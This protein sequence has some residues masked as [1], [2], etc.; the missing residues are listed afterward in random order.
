[1]TQVPRPRRVF[2]A[3]VVTALATLAVPAPSASAVPSPAG[4]TDARSVLSSLDHQ[5]LQALH[6]MATLDVGGLRVTDKAALRSAKP[7]DVIVQLS[8]PPAR[9]ARL[10]AAARGGSLSDAD[11]KAAVTKS[12]E[13]FRSALEDMFPS[14]SRTR[15]ST[16]TSTQPGLPTPSVCTA[17]TRTASTASASACQATASPTCSSRTGS[18]RSGRTEMKAFADHEAV[19][20]VAGR[21]PAAQGHLTTGTERRHRLPCSASVP[22]PLSVT[23]LRRTEHLHS[24]PRPMPQHGRTTLD[25]SGFRPPRAQV[26]AH[27]P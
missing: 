25:H 20:A 17:V 3:S 27:L 11:A 9:T 8:T 23:P 12:H 24:V 18:R 4:G 22:R 5:E 10:L 1:M 21:E 14:A 13:K 19:S 15:T 2:A 7:V 16:S 6:R 26:L